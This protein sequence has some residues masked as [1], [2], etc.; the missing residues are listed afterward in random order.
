MKSKITLL[1]VLVFCAVFGQGVID[2]TDI[3]LKSDKIFDQNFN[4]IQLDL[5]KLNKR[6][7]GLDSLFNTNK[8]VVDGDIN[9]LE[10][11][12]SN[13]SQNFNDQ[14]NLLNKSI[15]TNN[16]ELSNNLSSNT[17]TIHQNQS[18]AILQFDGL[19]KM[20]NSLT[21]SL[22]TNANSILRIKQQNSFSEAFLI[23]RL[24]LGANQ[25]FEWNGNIYKTDY[26]NEMKASPIVIAIDSLKFNL[27]KKSQELDDA[28]VKANNQIEILD[29]Y[30]EKVKDDNK[31]Q[32]KSLDQSINKTISDRTLYSIIIILVLLILLVIVFFFL[33]SKVAQQQD[34]LSSVKDAQEK[35]ENEAIQ[36]DTK[37]IQILEQELEVAQQQ[38][39]QTKEVDHSLPMKLGEEIH[40]MRKRLKIMDE[41]QGTKV[42]NKRI[43]SLEEKINDMGYEI[44]NLEGKPFNDGMTVQAKFV[45]DENLK[46]GESIIRRVIKPQINFNDNLIQTAEVE[47]AQGI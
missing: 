12:I 17:E 24:T 28:I 33:K 7:S 6:I 34:S 10:K 30:I 23:A 8:V 18:N 19:S 47:V 27:D 9:K 35:L 29:N 11:S 14:I 42:L 43:E 38:P 36:L 16:L 3:K 1:F 25:K 20:I 22:L 13:H 4:E 46:E 45:A 26:D 41:S 15:E 40:R 37:L 5:E 39:Q 44:V 21:D 32:I 2:T 31:S